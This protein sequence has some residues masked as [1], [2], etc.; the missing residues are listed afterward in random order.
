[1]FEDSSQINS[2]TVAKQLAKQLQML[3]QEYA[4]GVAIALGY[5]GSPRGTLDVDATLCYFAL[6]CV[7]K[8]SAGD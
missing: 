4:L 8:N 5:W 7:A 1:V 6:K 3:G 2:A